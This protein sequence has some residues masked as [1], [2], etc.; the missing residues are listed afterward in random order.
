MQSLVLLCLFFPFPLKV[1]VCWSRRV[2]TCS[3]GWSSI[4]IR[5]SVINPP[6][7][8]RFF[9]FFFFFLLFLFLLF[10]FQ[11]QQSMSYGVFKISRNVL[12]LDRWQLTL[13]Q[14]TESSSFIGYVTELWIIRLS[15]RFDWRS[16]VNHEFL[17]SSLCIHIY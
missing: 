1:S 13:M 16:D 6:F 3:I 4:R 8:V 2:T 10:F 12:L 7:C 15:S 14:H 5:K 17:S 9:F 11:R